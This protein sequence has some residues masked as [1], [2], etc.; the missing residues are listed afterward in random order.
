MLLV[1]ASIQ[2]A[3]YSTSGGGG[4]DGG[5][6]DLACPNC[7]STITYPDGRGSIVCVD[8]DH[9]WTPAPEEDAVAD[10]TDTDSEADGGGGGG[11][12]AVVDAMGNPLANGDAAIIINDLVVEGGK[13]RAGGGGALG[14]TG[15]QKTGALKKGTTVCTYMYR[16]D[17]AQLPRAIEFHAF[18]PRENRACV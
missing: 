14:K 12:E 7:D 5:E 9:T 2:K 8:C 4:D 6:E 13:V 16:L 3:W 17:F 15:S 10:T 18:V 11:G 1:G